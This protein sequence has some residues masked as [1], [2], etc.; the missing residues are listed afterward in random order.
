MKVPSISGRQVYTFRLEP[1]ELEALELRTANLRQELLHQVVLSNCHNVVG[2]MQA[3]DK[4]VLANA[5]SAI[6]NAILRMAR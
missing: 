5:F 1:T 2:N 6:A 3:S 4:T